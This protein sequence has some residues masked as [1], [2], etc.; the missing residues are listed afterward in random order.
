[1]LFKKRKIALVLGVII[2]MLFSS[3][4]AYA[5]EA[6]SSGSSQRFH[7]SGGG[8][9]GAPQPGS[10]AHVY[11][12]EGPKDPANG[13]IPKQGY[14]TRDHQWHNGAGGDS[15]YEFFIDKLDKKIESMENRT[16]VARKNKSFNGNR[17]YPEYKDVLK[18]ACIK[19]LNRNPDAQ[20]ARVVGVALTYRL[21]PDK[22]GWNI[23]DSM[24]GTKH[25]TSWDRLWSNQP[26]KLKPDY[27]SQNNGMT[28]WKEGKDG[29]KEY[30]WD[31]QVERDD[32]TYGAWYA[33]GRTKGQ[34]LYMRSK[35]ESDKGD[36]TGMYIV[37][38]AIAVT[39]FEPDSPTPV[40]FHKSSNNTSITDNNA[41]YSLAGAE[42]TI[43]NEG[44]GE[45]V[46]TLI[47]NAD[48]Y[49]DYIDLFPGD[50][51]AVETVSPKG[52][53]GYS[54]THHLHLGNDGEVTEVDQQEA[55]P[56]DD[57]SYSYTPYTDT[58]DDGKVS[59]VFDESK[60]PKELAINITEADWDDNWW[61]VELAVTDSGYTLVKNTKLTDKSTNATLSDGCHV[62][63]I[64][65]SVDEPTA[66]I[67]D[68]IS[69]A[70]DT[71]NPNDEMDTD[72]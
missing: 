41:Q 10:V 43:T 59:I 11:F 25:A 21:T 26:S 28:Y 39:E 38:Y 36:N 33:A 56:T 55:P 72:D 31:K 47:T 5:I 70:L 27:P 40:R 66:D 12:D 18:D 37:I 49:T 52:Y 57:P 4:P 8:S 30:Q 19:A 29:K 42:F 64:V 1:M 14:M 50:Y 45:L 22:K 32:P 44:T 24:S 68:G 2:C 23:A 6:A 65:N 71:R 17:A 15:T 62:F 61:L 9:G 7:S 3:V 48:G 13:D 20:Y 35:A 67:Q 16:L 46:G 60:T 69:Y 34:A 63:A 51:K 53:A 58:S 54:I